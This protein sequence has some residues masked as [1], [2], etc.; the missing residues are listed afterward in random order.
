M[1]DI[2]SI[3]LKYLNGAIASI[4][5]FSNGSKKYPKEQLQVF[6]KGKVY[7]IDNFKTFSINGSSSPFQ[8]LNQMDKG[9]RIQFSELTK[10]NSPFF[11]HQY[12]QDV[13]HSTE[14]TFAIKIDWESQLE[15]RKKELETGI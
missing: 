11:N 10:E 2:L 5:Y 12:Y 9:Y 4:Q 15:D 8:F 7:Q 14:V 3:Q 1:S 13:I 6:D